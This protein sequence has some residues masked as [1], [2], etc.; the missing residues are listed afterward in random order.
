MR[1]ATRVGG[2]AIRASRT[3][4][5]RESG[6]DPHQTSSGKRVARVGNGARFTGRALRL[7]GPAIN[8]VSSG[9]YRGA[10]ELRTEGSGM[11]AIN[12][13]DLDTYVRGVVAGEMPS[14][15][16][17]EALKAQAVAARTYA[18][19]TRKT[20]GCSTSIPT[21]APRSTAG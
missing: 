19:A 6:G 16:P 8:D 4:V 1:G 18:L 21:R 13:L 9:L 3:Y 10:I 15:W 17:L 5:A 14:S 11:T 20:T 7:L 2:R 12:V